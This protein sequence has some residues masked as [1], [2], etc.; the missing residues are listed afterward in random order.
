[1]KP[2]TCKLL[3]GI[4]L[5]SSC[6]IRED[7]TACPCR[8][9]LDLSGFAP[10]SSQVS[11]A[12]WEGAN[13][14]MEDAGTAELFVR[15]LAKDTFDASVWCNVREGMLSGSRLVIPQGAQ[16]DSLQVFRTRLS[17]TGET[18]TATAVPHRQHARITM[19][20]RMEAGIRYPYDF[21]AETDYCGIDLRDLSPIRGDLVFPIRQTEEDTYVFDLLRHGPDTQVRIAVHDKTEQID[22]LP[23]YEWLRTVG[24]DWEAPDLEDLTLYLDYVDHTIRIIIS[25]WHEGEVVDAV[26]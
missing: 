22:E 4:L 15:T 26:I 21:Y 8:L 6:T 23:L 11:V 1:M 13:T 10:I 25:N 20:V 3:T 14:R 12:F 9:E 24:Y 19:K 7:R 17:C 16:P 2:H 5:L 18:C